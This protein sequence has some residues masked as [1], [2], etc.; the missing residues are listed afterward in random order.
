MRTLSAADITWAIY[1]FVRAENR[2]P[3]VAPERQSFTQAND[4]DYRKSAELSRIRS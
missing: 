2:Y 4:N 3:N 1:K